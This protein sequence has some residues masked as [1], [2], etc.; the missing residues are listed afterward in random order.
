ML[1][2]LIRKNVCTSQALLQ[3]KKSRQGKSTFFENTIQHKINQIKQPTQE[4]CIELVET[5]AAERTINT[6]SA[7]SLL[8]AFVQCMHG[9]L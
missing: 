7:P 9:V 5:V 8:L 4:G 1:Q 6:F 2:Y 3:A